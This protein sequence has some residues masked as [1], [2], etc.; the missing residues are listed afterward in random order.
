VF[1]KILFS[2]KLD[3]FEAT[4]DVTLGLDFY[5]YHQTD[6]DLSW[7]IANDKVAFHLHLTF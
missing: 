7:H 3:L 5:V 6:G 4:S 1:Y 2:D